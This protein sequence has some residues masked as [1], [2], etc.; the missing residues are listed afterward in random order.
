SLG[1]F[2]EFDAP[3]EL[4]PYDGEYSPVPFVRPAFHGISWARGL[5]DLASAV[6]EGRPHRAT[7]RQAADVVDIVEAA[8]TSM[9]E[10]GRAVEVSSTFDPVPLMPWATLEVEAER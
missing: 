7:G 4:G 6:A 10:D 5:A 8:A 1:S 9:R 3:V 2:Q